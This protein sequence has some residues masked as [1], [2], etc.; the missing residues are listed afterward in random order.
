MNSFSAPCALIETAHLSI[1]REQRRILDDVCLRIMPHEVLSIIG[2]NGAGKS[3]LIK[4]LLG[5]TPPDSG[6]VA[7]RTSLR[8]GYVP[9]RLSVPKNIP[10]NAHSFITLS[11]PPQS[12]QR[13]DAIIEETGIKKLLGCT[14]HSLSGGELQHIL[15]ARALIQ[16]PHLIILDEP[17]QNL[18]YASHD[19]FYEVLARLHQRDRLS[20]V[21]VS[22]DVPRVLRCST[23]IIALHH[24][25]CC[26]GTPAQ[27]IHDPAFISLFGSHHA[28]LMP[29]IAQP[30][31][32]AL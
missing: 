23:R 9:Q 22:H 11:S 26:E 12:A 5:I 21:M 25:I 31:H 24:R 15:L 6:T 16:Q 4:C 3:M 29:T 19:A 27:I 18:D 10:I 14:M 1:I 20:I 32:I 17:A 13:I 7:K 2:P 30:T 28:P 8:I